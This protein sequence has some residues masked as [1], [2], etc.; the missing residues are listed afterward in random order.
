MPAIARNTD[1]TVLVPIYK[2]SL[3]GG[4]AGTVVP[5]VADFIT[6]Q[7]AEHG[8]DDVSVYGDSAGGAIALSAMQEL[9]RRGDLVPG[10]MVLQFRRAS[11]SPFATRP[12]RL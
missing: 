12:S 3:Y 11:T 10:H 7:V 9:V 5:A 4:T 1:A 6:A 8:T 2:L